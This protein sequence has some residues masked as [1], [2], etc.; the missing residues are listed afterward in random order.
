MMTSK[1]GS[2]EPWL[3][4]TAPFISRIYWS[5]AKHSALPLT[6]LLLSQ[7]NNLLLLSTFRYSM[8]SYI[9]PF[10]IFAFQLFAPFSYSTFGYSQFS[11]FAVRIFNVLLVNVQHHNRRFPTFFL[12]ST[13]SSMSWLFTRYQRYSALLRRGL[14]P[15]NTDP[16]LLFLFYP[17]FVQVMPC[18]MSLL[19][20]PMDE[21]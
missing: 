10:V 9:W 21:I 14:F 15:H 20:I 17:V 1:Y 3:L 6:G 7:I 4:L 19:C 11:F 12:G 2:K 18:L 16:I 8:F 5:L 13:F